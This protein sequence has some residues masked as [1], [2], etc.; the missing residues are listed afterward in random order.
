[1]NAWL[2]LMPH[3]E[4]APERLRE[5]MHKAVDRATGNSIHVQ[6]AHAATECLRAALQQ[7]T[8]K[9]AALDLLSA[10]ALLTHACAAAAEA[11][12]DELSRF[13]A[14]L[15]ANHFQDILDER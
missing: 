15:D 1:M 3:V 8:S 4:E 5:K 14:M 10:D 13:T 11:G 12:A 6:L 9:A 7:P 2:W